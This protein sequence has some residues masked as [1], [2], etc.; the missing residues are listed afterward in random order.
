MNRS[1]Q[2]DEILRTVIETHARELDRRGRTIRVPMK[3]RVSGLVIAVLVWLGG[4]AAAQTPLTLQITRR[5]RHASR[6]ECACPHH[7]CGMGAAS[8]A[9]RS[10]TAI[11]LPGSPVTLELEGVPG[12]AGARHHPARR[13]RIHA[14]GSRR[15]RASGASMYDRIMILPTSVAPRNPPPTAAA[16]IFPGGPGGIVRPIVPRQAEDQNGNDD[17]DAATRRS[18]AFRS[19]VPCLFRVQPACLLVVPWPANRPLRRIT[20]AAAPQTPAPVVVTPSNPFGLPRV[21]PRGPA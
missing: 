2:L 15:R 13:E 6:A 9:P 20:S 8:A 12:A 10:S 3:F 21:L 18:M 11:A 4:A 17:G 14:G 16:P 19:R 7:S 1:V 5:T